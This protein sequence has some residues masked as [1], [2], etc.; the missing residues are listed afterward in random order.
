LGTSKSPRHATDREVSK[1]PCPK[2]GASTF[3]L[4]RASQARKEYTGELNQEVMAL[5]TEQGYT[6]VVALGI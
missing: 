2:D 5:I 6:L 4:V 1:D 3:V